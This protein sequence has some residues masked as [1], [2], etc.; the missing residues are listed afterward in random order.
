MYMSFSGFG[1]VFGG[2]P[3]S[4]GDF[5]TPC[6]VLG[7]WRQA[8]K[9]HLGATSPFF[10]QARPYPPTSPTKVHQTLI[11]DDSCNPGTE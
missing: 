9:R 3:D 8:G 1:S 10:F 6:K 11:L 2:I 5:M 7:G 4:V